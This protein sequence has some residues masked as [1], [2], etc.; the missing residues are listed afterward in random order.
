MPN[1]EDNGASV[2]PGNRPAFEYTLT[3]LWFYLLIML[4]MSSIR[5][6]LK[7]VAMIWDMSLLNMLNLVVQFIVIYIMVL[8]WKLPNISTRAT[9][10]MNH[11]VFDRLMFQLQDVYSLSLNRSSLWCSWR[12]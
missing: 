10:S 2:A 6:V 9:D 4:N 1:T 3:L 7:L 5:I 12:V 11:H 8:T